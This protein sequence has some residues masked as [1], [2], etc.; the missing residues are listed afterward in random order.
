MEDLDI[1]ENEIKDPYAEKDTLDP[2][3]L[4]DE[5]DS[6]PQTFRELDDMRVK[7]STSSDV[8]FVQM[9]LNTRG[10][11]S[12]LVGNFHSFTLEVQEA[13]DRY[14]EITDTSQQ[15]RL[16]TGQ[17]ARDAMFN[18]LKASTFFSFDDYTG[19]SAP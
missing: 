4:L 17:A 8:S 16:L 13:D 18:A 11:D 7:L 2:K 1:L 10:A 3:S 19:T 12:Q 9:Q 15:V 14:E 5:M 6:F